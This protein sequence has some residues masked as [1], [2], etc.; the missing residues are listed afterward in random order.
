MSVT[1]SG[2]LELA[3]KAFFQVSVIR[4]MTPQQCTSRKIVR[5]SVLQT[6]S[7]KLINKETFNII[8][9]TSQTKSMKAWNFW[10]LLKQRLQL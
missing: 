9:G 7:Q 1:S 5:L 4:T 8:D 2:K 6:D 10:L 3:T